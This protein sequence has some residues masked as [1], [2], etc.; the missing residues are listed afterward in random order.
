MSRDL[1]V[2]AQLYALAF[3]QGCALTVRLCSLRHKS[4]TR[5]SVLGEAR[6]TSKSLGAKGS[7]SKTTNIVCTR[8][9]QVA[10]LQQPLVNL[11]VHE[12]ESPARSGDYSGSWKDLARASP[13]CPK[14]QRY[15]C[16][17]PRLG[18]LLVTLQ[19]CIRS[20]APASTRALTSAIESSASSSFRSFPSH[21]L[22]HSGI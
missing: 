1:T 7:L 11:D 12:N 3:G 18:N 19:A 21:R 2:V 9:D 15:K 14:Q 13:D 17:T 8:C 16:V 5:V 6:P 22:T 20:M 10:R 4:M